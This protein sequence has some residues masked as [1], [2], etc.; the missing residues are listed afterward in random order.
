MPAAVEFS[1]VVEAPVSRVYEYWR[2]WK[3]V[4]LHVNVEDVR[5]TGPGITHWVVRALERRWS[6]TPRPPRTRNR[7][8]G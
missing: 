2:I 5:S 7:A 6:S 8:I 3:P 1:V 4:Q